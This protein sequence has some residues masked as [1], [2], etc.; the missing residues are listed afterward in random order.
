MIQHVCCSTPKSYM[1]TKPQALW[2]KFYSLNWDFFLPE[3][4]PFSGRNPSLF[5]KAQFLS[6]N[7][8]PSMHW[9][10][11]TKDL[12]MST[13][14]FSFL[15][16][17]MAWRQFTLRLFLS[18]TTSLGTTEEVGAWEISCLQT[19]HYVSMQR[20]RSSDNFCHQPFNIL[21]LCKKHNFVVFT[22][23]EGRRLCKYRH[24]MFSCKVPEG[25]KGEKG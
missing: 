12:Q 16:G 6:E 8:F 18:R 25:E 24:V 17:N 13:L 4:I 21:S 23:E 5:R 10:F 22:G 3:I 14:F 19:S 11:A 20:Q 15:N 2:Y 9:R 7:I 1:L